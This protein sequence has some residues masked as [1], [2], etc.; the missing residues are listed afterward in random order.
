MTR[1]LRIVTLV[2]AATA[3][4]QAQQYESESGF[5]LRGT[6]SAMAAGSTQ[7][8]KAP[9]TT[10]DSLVDGGV[11]LMLYPTWKLSSHWMFYGAFQG[12]SRPYYYSTFETQGHG[13]H[14]N[15]VQGYLSYTQVWKDSSVQ[16]KVGQLSSAFGSFALRY[17][18]RDNP[19]VDVPLQYGYYGSLATLAGLAGAEIDTTWKKLDGR[20]QFTNSSPSNPRSV[21]ASEQY[22]NWAGGGGI[23]IRQGLRV[24][25]SGYRGPYADRKY[26][27]YRPSDGLPRSL[28]GS[29]VGADAEWGTGH[30]NVRGEIQRFVMQYGPRPAFHEHTG[31]VEAERTLGPRW[32]VATRFSYLS[33]DHIGHA[34]Q[35]ETAVA[36]RSGVNQSIKIS[37]ETAHSET[38]SGPN[39]TLA[40]QFVTAIHP[41]AFAG[42]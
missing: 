42:R 25:V 33:A 5:G 35:I 29:G 34:Q 12:V 20:V 9:R 3:A 19:L 40:V 24:G 23:T 37:Y 18:D 8:Q 21:F 13:L 32:Y 14:G 17:D 16:V 38:V 1:A 31:Y 30:W 4:L 27:F 28:P 6:F 7:F 22:G 15:L 2:C 39:R 36:Y 11:R 26:P 41:L 10:S